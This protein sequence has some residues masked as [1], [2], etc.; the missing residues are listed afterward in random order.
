MSDASLSTAGQDTWIFRLFAERLKQGYKGFFIEAGASD[1][2]P[3]S[4]TYTL[5]N[6]YGWNGLLVEPNE[7]FFAHL[8]KTRK[9][10]CRQ[11][12]LASEDGPIEFIQ[13]GYYGTAPAFVKSVFETRGL[14]LMKHP[15]YQTDADG[16]TAKVSLLQGRSLA[17]LLDEIKAPDI[18]DYFSL[19]VEGGEVA[20]LSGFPFK[21]RRIRAL[22]AEA[23][24]MMNGVYYATDHRRPVRELLE[25]NGYRFVGE[26]DHDDAYVLD[27]IMPNVAALPMTASSSY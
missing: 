23:R 14:D 1:G 15:N 18:I 2:G 20:V 22:T 3:G 16:A 6:T 21:T 9:A 13:A 4:N 12:V 24:F 26:L 7:R 19:D 10:A 27:E 17:S 5:E 25:A 11:V 8:S